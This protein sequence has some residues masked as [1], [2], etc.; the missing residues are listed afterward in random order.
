MS[1]YIVKHLNKYY[2]FV[3]LDEYHQLFLKFWKAN[4]NSEK[5][6]IPDDLKKGIK[7]MES[8]KYTEELVYVVA[9]NFQSK[10]CIWGSPLWWFVDTETMIYRLIPQD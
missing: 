9:R 10:A 6:E 2:K 3:L 7:H 8:E 5:I 1:I 4:R